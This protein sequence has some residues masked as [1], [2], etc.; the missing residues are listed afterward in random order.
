MSASTRDVLIKARELIATPDRWT[1][2]A[3]WRSASGLA[4]GSDPDI[5]SCCALGAIWLV[6][7]MD[8]RIN[9]KEAQITLLKVVGRKIS[10]WNDA[11]WRTH[12]EVLAAF[13][14]A[15]EAASP[16]IPASSQEAG[17]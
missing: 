3:A 12:D 14:Q 13:D 17:Q 15:I 10:D 16:A 6:G 2:G 7:R 4:T 9:T 5:R 8:I 11:P 1:K